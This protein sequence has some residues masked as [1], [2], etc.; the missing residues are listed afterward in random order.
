MI[1]PSAFCP[2]ISLR[3]VCNQYYC[4]S[5]IGDNGDSDSE[6]SDEDESD[7]SDGGRHEMV[8]EVAM[9]MWQ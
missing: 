6:S 2:A 4:Q 7:E 8:M 3:A 1:I 5:F 9:V